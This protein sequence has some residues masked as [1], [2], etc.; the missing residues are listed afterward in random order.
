MHPTRPDPSSP[1]HDHSRSCARAHAAGIPCSEGS[2]R[3]PYGGGA[4]GVLPA[5]VSRTNVTTVLRLDTVATDAYKPPGTPRT[6]VYYNPADHAVWVR[7][8]EPNAARGGDGDARTTGIHCSV[9]DAASGAVLLRSACCRGDAAS[10]PGSEGSE[11][12][13]VHPAPGGTCDGEPDAA[14][15][16]AADTAVVVAIKPADE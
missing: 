13:G 10:S 6:F 15:L 16:L 7:V 12:E 8:A 2:D 1:V 11:G 4:L 3:A 5:V 14:L 9:H